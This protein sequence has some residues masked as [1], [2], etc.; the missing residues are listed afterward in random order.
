MYHIWYTSKCL[1]WPVQFVYTSHAKQFTHQRLKKINWN[2]SAHWCVGASKEISHLKLLWFLLV[3]SMDGLGN[4]NNF[5]IIARWGFSW[6]IN[7]TILLLQMSKSR[8]NVVDPVDRLKKYTPDGFRYFLLKEG[9]PHSDGSKHVLLL[10]FV[11]WANL[12]CN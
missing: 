5:G 10:L 6:P 12:S 9:V 1:R 11:I 4:E 2:P 7:F 8:G 3:V